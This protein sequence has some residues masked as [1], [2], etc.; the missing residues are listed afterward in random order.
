VS[1]LCSGIADNG[2]LQ[3]Q[4]AGV[5]RSWFGGIVRSLE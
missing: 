3:I 5:V 1:G 4:T 2:A